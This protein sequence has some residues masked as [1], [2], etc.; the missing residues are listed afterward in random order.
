MA[1][2]IPS[3]EVVAASLTTEFSA[4]L[5]KSN[6]HAHVSDFTRV[7]ESLFFVEGEQSSSLEIKCS[8]WI[9][10][11]PDNAELNSDVYLTKSY[12]EFVQI[13]QNTFKQVTKN[14][15]LGE[16][17]SDDENESTDDESDDEKDS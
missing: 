12:D 1:T 5:E 9:L 2:E 13:A 8:R 17:G 16:D 10:G 14:L 11:W 6:L 7:N 15:N 3:V 4:I